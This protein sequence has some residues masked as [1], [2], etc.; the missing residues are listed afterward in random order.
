[1]LYIISKK[2]RVTI[3]KLLEQQERS[4]LWLSRK[5]GIGNNNLSNLIKNKTISV[6]FENL[7]KICEVLN[8]DLHDILILEEVDDN[9]IEDL[10][11]KKAD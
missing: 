11:N 7:E 1:M 5:T 2:I 8:C 4:C 9:K 6:R 10:N 3:D